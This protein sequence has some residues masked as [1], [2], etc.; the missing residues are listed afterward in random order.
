MKE[1]KEMLNEEVLSNTFLKDI[2]Q[3]GSLFNLKSGIHPNNS[4]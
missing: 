1:M 4:S 3:T 2:K